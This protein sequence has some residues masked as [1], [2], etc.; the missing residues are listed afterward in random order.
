VGSSI[1][2][3]LLGIYIGRTE[4]ERSKSFLLILGLVIG[5]GG[6]LVFKYYNF[7]IDS[8]IGAFSTFNINLN[9]HSLNLILPLG[10]SF[11]TFRAI[12]YLLDINSEKIKPSTDIVIV[13]SYIAFFPCLVAGPI[14][15]AGTF[16][17]QM[18]S[19][20][21]FDY[22]QARDAMQQILWGL[23][24]KVV[25]ADNCAKCANAIFEN[26]LSLPASSL[27]LGAFFYI[28][29]IYA[30]FS[31]YSDMAIGFSQ[32][33]GFKVTKN[34]NFPFFAQN[35]SEFWQKWH[36][37]LT[38]WMTEYVFTPLAFTFRKSG[39]PGLILAI[40]INFILIGLWHG[41]NW[42]FILYG[43]L[44]GCY[45]IP[46]VLKGTL[47]KK[48][49]NTSNNFFPSFKVFRRIAGLFILLMLTV[50]LFRSDS[51]SDAFSYYWSLFS[52]SLFSLPQVPSGR[53]SAIVSLIFILIM[54]IVEWV[55]RDKDFGLQISEIKS[56]GIRLSIY[57]AIIFAILIFA[58]EKVTFIYAQF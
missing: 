47:N 40:I 45:F 57:Y 50:I 15:R 23:F 48:R 42:T 54:F 9:L 11:Y 44:H 46:L 39:K 21:R 12:S 2:N 53:L 5:A 10:I 22:N 7:F 55:Q 6:L 14:D 49:Q 38:S 3:Y 43:F 34:F 17:P 30:D 18:E 1:A 27:L 16:F 58:G 24:K 28:I 31:G 33:L 25:I 51:I 35:I 36:I 8:L 37:S 56:P 52:V 26:H 4:N 32:L 41:A 20:R 29:Q 13:F 19:K